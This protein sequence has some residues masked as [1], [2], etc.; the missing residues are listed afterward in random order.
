MGSIFILFPDYLV[1]HRVCFESQKLFLF[2]ATLS[3]PSL[4]YFL[5][6][7]ILVFSNFLKEYLAG[8]TRS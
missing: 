7:L 1:F 2:R 5:D 6:Y 4:S 8:I 3:S